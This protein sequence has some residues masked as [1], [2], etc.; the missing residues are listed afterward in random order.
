LW[1]ISKVQ[2]GKVSCTFWTLEPSCNMQIT[3]IIVRSFSMFS[4]VWQIL[5][6]GRNCCNSFLRAK[7]SHRGIYLTVQR[8]WIRNLDKFWLS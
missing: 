8:V 6:P 3:S 2:M 4:H 7:I 5:D 1:S